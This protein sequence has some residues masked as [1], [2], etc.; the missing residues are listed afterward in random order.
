[1]KI[2]LVLC[3]LTSVLCVLG[4]EYVGK[5]E[6]R[7]RYICPNIELKADSTFVMILRG[8]FNGSCK[9]TWTIK[10]DSVILKQR[11]Q[12]LIIDRLI[13][14]ESVLAG[15]DLGNSNIIQILSP[16]KLKYNGYIMK[17]KK[18]KQK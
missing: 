14:S 2:I 3:F 4:Q 7:G 9:G 15:W 10:G 17:R 11:K 6:R 18:P 8:G 12:R 5:F 13:V 16:N 1:M